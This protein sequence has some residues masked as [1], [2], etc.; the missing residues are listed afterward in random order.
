M[1]SAKRILLTVPFAVASV[2]TVLVAFA[3]KLHIR[4]Q[5]VAGYGFLFATPWAWLIERLWM[6]NCHN[7]W[8]EAILG[9]VVI[10]WIPATLYSVCLWL[11]MRAFRI[12]ARRGSD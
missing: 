11:V 4:A 6:P 10:L 1:I 9:Y 5:R 3:D 7:G 8:I 2:L 12:P